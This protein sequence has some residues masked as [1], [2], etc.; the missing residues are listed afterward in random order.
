MKRRNAI[1]VGLATLVATS[2]LWATGLVSLPW[3]HDL[4]Y[5]ISIKPQEMPLMP[6]EG[7]VPVTG[8]VDD[9]AKL[10]ADRLVNPV[11]ADTMSLRRGQNAYGTYCTPCH[12]ATGIGDGPV[13]KSLPIPPVDLTRADLQSGRTDGALYHTIRHGNVIMPGYA[14]ALTPERAW[15]V[16][17]YIRTL[18]K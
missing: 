9:G 18:K 3:T 12:G 14:Y 4:D 17:H 5:Q 15:D 2:L 13:A 7:V 11:V 1:L 10:D 6:P 16:V 8:T